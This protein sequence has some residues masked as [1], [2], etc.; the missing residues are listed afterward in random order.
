MPLLEKDKEILLSQSSS[1]TSGEWVEFFNDRYPRKQLLD[2][3]RTH[4]IKMRKTTEAEFSEL[5]SKRARKYNINQDYFK[6]WSRNM[7]YLFGFWFADGCIYRGQMFDITVHKKDKYIL[8]KFADELGFEGK[9]YDYVDR[10]AA[11]I[12]FSCKVIHDDIIA[13]GGKECKSL[14]CKFPDVPRR[15]LPDFIR[16]YFDGD[17]CVCLC[18]NNRLQASFASGSPEFL[19]DLHSI[20]KEEAGIV[21]GSQSKWSLSFGKRDSLLLGR[22]MYKNEPELYLKRKYDKFQRF[23]AIGEAD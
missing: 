4:D 11:R 8:K 10:Q 3:C 19:E 9:L 18:K 1:R 22:Y 13:L 17:G 2:F 20:L 21:G 14:D 16:G 5:Q 6:T 7:A 23:D 12:N 15:Y